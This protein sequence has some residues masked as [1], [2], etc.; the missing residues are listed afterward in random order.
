MKH[1]DW[2]TLCLLAELEGEEHLTQRA[3]ATRIGVAVGLANS[4]LKRAVTKGYVKV[5]NAPAR[6]YAYYVTPQ[7]FCEK[8]RLVAEYMSSSLGFFRQAR[9]EYTDIF[10][11][12]INTGHRRV[13]LYGVGE[14]A[15]IA[16]MSLQITDLDVSCI[17]QPDSAITDFSGLTVLPNVESLKGDEIDVVVIT[18][19]D[20]PQM[21]Y[22]ALSKHME[23][24]HIYCPPMLR[25]L[26][27]AREQRDAL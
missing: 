15:E 8:S 11:K 22:D 24:A 26:R 19:A 3:L 13:A 6:R 7:G 25:V 9:L 27:R 10:E 1:S 23:E 4:L 16:I 5:R 18:S 14:L 2:A 17:V 21:A 12:I 20:S